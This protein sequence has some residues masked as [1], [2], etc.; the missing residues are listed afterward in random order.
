MI[1][2]AVELGGEAIPARLIRH[3]LDV[4][5]A[6]LNHLVELLE[7]IADA[8]NARAECGRLVLVIKANYYTGRASLRRRAWATTSPA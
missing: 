8:L 4:G 1:E 7:G 5:R 6:L 2:T 3:I